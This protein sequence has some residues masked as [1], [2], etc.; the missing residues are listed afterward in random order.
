LLGAC[1]TVALATAWG[2]PAEATIVHL[3]VTPTDTLSQTIVLFFHRNNSFDGRLP[4]GVVPG[5]VTSRFDYDLPTWAPEDFTGT[6]AGYILVGLHGTGP[7]TGVALSFPNDSP[8]TSGQTWDSL[9]QANTGWAEQTAID[10][11]NSPGPFDLYNSFVYQAEYLFKVPFET[12]ATI[13]DFSGATSGGT[14]FATIVPE[15]S[16]WALLVCGAG[17][18]AVSRRRHE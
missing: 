4:L 5:G 18:I 9:I 7:T 16:T 8:I 11:L 12:Q 17:V 3:S 15:P 14:A 1:L 2:A 13:V 10:F 6:Y